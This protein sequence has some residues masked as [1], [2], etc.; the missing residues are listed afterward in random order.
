MSFIDLQPVEDSWL[1]F[2][3]K[4][5]YRG[6]QTSATV[7]TS[8]GAARGRAIFQFDMT[9]IPTHQKVDSATFSYKVTDISGGAVALEF[10]LLP[11]A[12][13]L[14][15][16]ETWNVWKTGSSWSAGGGDI[17]AGLGWV[18]GSVQS[19][20]GVKT[21]NLLTLFDYA[22]DTQG[23]S[24]FFGFLV[25]IAGD[26]GTHVLAIDTIEGTTMPFIRFHVN[27]AKKSVIPP[28]GFYNGT[29]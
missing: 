23:I 7:S 28:R 14:I 18:A 9:Q 12:K 4:A 19:G 1:D 13:R 25:R 17:D 11:A 29:P 20:T 6:A 2:D 22:R 26:V 10:G 27:S 5:T 24:D 15:D 3:S 8:G 21:D 16:T